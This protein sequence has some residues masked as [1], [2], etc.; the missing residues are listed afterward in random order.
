MADAD[1][2][3]AIEARI[4]AE[5]VPLLAKPRNDGGYDCCGCSTYQAIVDDVL[6]I[7]RNED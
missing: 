4:Q 2:R 1:V 5:V 6:A 7:V 3:K